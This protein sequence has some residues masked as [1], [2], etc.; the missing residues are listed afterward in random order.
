M[1]SAKTQSRARCV[2]QTEDFSLDEEYQTLKT[3]YRDAGA[4]VTFSGLVRELSKDGKQL[5][6]IEL[7]TYP[8]M[9]HKQLVS[10]A[11]QAL[12]RFDIDGL[13]IIHRYGLLGPNEQ[14]VFVG[15][16][17]AH[18]AESFLAAEMLMDQLKS[19]VAF[20]KKEHFASHPNDQ[21]TQNYQW[22]NTKA[23]DEEALKRWS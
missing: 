16:A 18:R 10:L 11:D 7:E 15:V 1:P 22:I 12:N 21:E 9:A 23:S 13:T 2:L 6:G 5:K 20:W 14:I 17:S 19:N 3:Q 8:D 4:I